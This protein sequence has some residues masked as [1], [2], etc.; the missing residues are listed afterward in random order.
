MKIIE[1]TIHN[2]MVRLLYAD[3]PTKEEAS[4]WVEM[5]VKVKRDDNRRLGVIQNEAL[6]RLRDLLKAED[7]R[8][9]HLSDQLRK[10]TQSGE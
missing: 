5:Q 4:E 10:Q 1:T 3:K 8:F 6:K 9:E 2:G 7:A